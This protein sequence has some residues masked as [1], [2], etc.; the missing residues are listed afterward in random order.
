M[1][2]RFKT[3][4]TEDNFLNALSKTDLRTAGYIAGVVG[5][6]LPTAKTYLKSLTERNVIE[7]V[8]IDD[9]EII[10]YKLKDQ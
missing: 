6:T 7:V 2:H 3:Q 9:G 5:C 10:A 1:R 4:Y 8:F